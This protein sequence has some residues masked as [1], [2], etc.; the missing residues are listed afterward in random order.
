MALPNGGA[1]NL[2]KATFES[3]YKDKN[4]EWKSINSFGGYE[5]SLVKW[6]IGQG[7]CLF[8]QEELVES[9]ESRS[10]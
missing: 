10:F 7:V 5:I 6:Y 8:D 4:G 3:R 9:H 1:K 2:L